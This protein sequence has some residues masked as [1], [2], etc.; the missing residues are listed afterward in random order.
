MKVSVIISLIQED[1][2]RHYEIERMLYS[3][4][5]QNIKDVEIIISA[6]NIQ[7]LKNK[8]KNS[9]IKY[10]QTR[11]ENTPQVLNNSVASS[12]SDYICFL[13]INS[14]LL[15]NSLSERLEILRQNPEYIACYSFGLDADQ[16]FK[17]KQTKHNNIFFYKMYDNLP[18]NNIKSLLLTDIIPD[19]A[20]IT[21][22][23]E[24][25]NNIKFDE[26]LDECYALDFFINLFIKYENK[27]KQLKEPL[28]LNNAHI[29]FK[30]Y[31]KKSLVLKSLNQ[32]SHVYDK[33]FKKDT[34]NTL[35]D[36]KNKVYRSL[37]LKY[38]FIITESYSGDFKLLFYIIGSYLKK[39]ANNKPDIYDFYFVFILLKNISNIRPKS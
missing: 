30:N 7:E 3:V 32:H 24:I 29:D 27:I 8:H 17:A 14:L 11:I 2:A 10:I 31:K 36:I 13:D 33:F 21:V 37:Y 28:Y 23:K 26:N 15:F 5:N 38:L 16:D 39:L 18:E 35:S 25:F 34:R 20:S 22:K 9:C 19:L 1:T 12:S 4:L 6:Y